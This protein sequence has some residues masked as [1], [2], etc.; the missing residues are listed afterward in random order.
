MFSFDKLNRAIGGGED[1][2]AIA[3]VMVSRWAFEGLMVDQFMNNPFEK[4]LF[5]IEKKES[6][7]S[8][9]QGKPSIGGTFSRV[10]S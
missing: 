6:M 9:K 2:P 4:E 10:E 7:A 1:V 8:F 5:E 3:E